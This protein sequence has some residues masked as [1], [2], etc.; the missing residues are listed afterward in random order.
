MPP[1]AGQSL[2]EATA[3]QSYENATQASANFQ[4]SC[5]HQADRDFS[6]IYDKL[7]PVMKM[8][9]LYSFGGRKV[10]ET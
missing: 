7:V 4:L 8:T 9:R 10:E 1:P 6:S 3:T 2:R 5:D